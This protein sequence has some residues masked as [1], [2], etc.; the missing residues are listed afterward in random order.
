MGIEGWEAWAQ[1]KLTPV[2]TLPIPE[3][4]NIPS[5]F[6]RR[7]NKLGRCVVSVG[8]HCSQYIVGEPAVI[9]VSRHGDL[10]SM[11]KIIQCSR[12]YGDISPTAFSYSVHNR[13]SSL[14]SMISKYRGV[15]GAYSSVRDGFPLA[16]AEAESLINEKPSLQVI[17]VAYEPEIL[18]QYNSLISQA[19]QPHVFGFV[20]SHQK[21]PGKAFEF[22]LTAE[23]DSEAKEDK[24]NESGT[25]LPFVRSMF[26]S[27]GCR[28]GRWNYQFIN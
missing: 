9:S 3:L 20:L 5:K 26:N 24:I 23:I 2:A 17:I 1:H 8:E 19:W 14:I 11:D 15:N 10:S 4:V 25:C 6:S 27:E 13:F 18:S 22:S 28:D 16:L 12:E 7:L 21:T